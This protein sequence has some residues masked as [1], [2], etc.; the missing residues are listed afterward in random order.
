MDSLSTR[1]VREESTKAHAACSLSLIRLVL[2]EHLLREV[3]DVLKAL[4][5][6]KRPIDEFGSVARRDI[7]S[8]PADDRLIDETG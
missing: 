8:D 4:Y 3:A 7:L 5:S 1:N 6:L 2:R